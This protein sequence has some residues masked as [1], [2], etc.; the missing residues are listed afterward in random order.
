[1]IIL[2]ILQPYQP[3]NN[4]LT[5]GAGYTTFDGAYSSLSGRPTIPTNN[6]QL[7]NGAEFI[8]ASDNITGTSAGL[9]GTPN[10]TV[11]SIIASTGTFSGNVTIGGT[12]TY[13]DVTNI[14]SVGLITARSGI[15][16]GSGIT[17]SP[18]GDG[19]FTGVTT[20][21]TFVGNLTGNVTGTASNATQLNSQAASYYLDYDN[22]SNTPTIP[23]NNNQLTNGAG[24]ITGSALNASNLSSGTIPDA[25]FPSTL[26]AIDGSA[27]TGIAGTANVRTGILDVAGIATFRND[28]LVG[29]G[30]TLSP[31][32]DGFYTGIVTATSF[33]GDGS[34]LTN[35]PAGT[36]DKIS[37]G[38]TKA[39][40]EDTGSTGRFFVETEG[41][42][43]FS[44]DRT[45]DFRFDT[46]HDNVINANGNLTIDFKMS[47]STKVRW[48]VGV[49]DTKL[50]LQGGEDYPLNIWG[51]GNSS[52]DIKLFRSG[53][54]T[55]GTTIKLNGPSGIITATKFIGDGS[56]LTG[57]GGTE[58]V[59]TGILDVAGIATFRND[60][61]IGTGV[62]LSP[63]GDIFATGVTTSTSFVG[64]L[65]GDVTG[66][67]SKRH[68][69][70]QCP[71]FNR[72]T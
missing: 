13:E 71:R 10:I 37:E 63:D 68:T 3:N 47:N 11:G 23:T 15:K 32:G 39:E 17:L 31:D 33:V 59:R 18:D 52:K 7:T 46:A 67:A 8:T 58:N 30:I 65:T 21:T 4:Q 62:T 56:E 50:Y 51:A 24:Y 49:A 35:L 25:R 55:V 2:L 44:I 28:T 43:R 9:T 38:N 53:D 48:I 36:S 64:D 34:A 57:I 26:P 5:N 29:S 42:E 72:I 6:N 14:D 69:C 61:L 45:G 1:M 54:V 16:V 12:L 60:T 66:T 27:L 19:F 40:V 20:S 22:F 41:T 70:S